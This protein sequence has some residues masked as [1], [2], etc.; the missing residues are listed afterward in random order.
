LVGFG[1]SAGFA[2]LALPAL[3]AFEVLL[4]A[5]PAW[6]AGLSSIISGASSMSAIGEIILIFN[7]RL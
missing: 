4:L 3:L 1:G 5:L 6:E 2:T 7:L